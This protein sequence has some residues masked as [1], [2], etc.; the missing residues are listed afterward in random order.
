MKT[1]EHVGKIKGL[2]N[3]YK[4]T[5]VIIAAARLGVFNALSTS[6]MTSAEVAAH[7]GVRVEKIE[8]VM[9]ALVHF[10]VVEKKN[11]VFSL[12]E[13]K[14]VLD[15]NSPLCQLGYINHALNMSDKWRKLEE[16]VKSQEV[17]I[18]NF[19]GITGQSEDQTR[20]FLQAMNTNAVPQAEYLVSHYDF[21]DHKFIDIGAGYGTY[22]MR[23]AKA[24]ETSKGVSLDL[25]MAAKIIAGNIE[26]ENLSNRVKVIGGD[27]KKDLPNEKFND[28]FLFAIIHQESIEE[29]CKLI[30]SVFDLLEDDGKL[31][32]T[33][34]FLNDDRTEPEFS[35]LFGVEMLVGSQNGRAY[36]HSEIHQILKD[37]G[38]RTIEAVKEVPGPATLYV[39][40]K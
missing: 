23:V 15:P 21:T 24:F 29:C 35:V 5:Y 14:D 30:K 9:N 36:S 11:E 26:A 6:P 16:T 13:Y 40:T 39:A 22:S 32:L 4:S 1:N 7:I 27:Y 12:S 25:P 18:D 20:A 3:G 10:G 31:Y 19:N 28:A 37:T 17:S 38:F 34:F 8:P 33:S 2:V